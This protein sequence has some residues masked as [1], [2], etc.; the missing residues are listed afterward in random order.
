MLDSVEES[1]NIYDSTSNEYLS[2]VEY[3]DLTKDYLGN[4]EYTTINLARDTE[5]Y[6]LDQMASNEEYAEEQAL[7]VF[8][9][10]SNAVRQLPNKIKELT[11][12]IITKDIGKHID[13]RIDEYFKHH[14]SPQKEQVKS[15]IDADMRDILTELFMQ[16][17]QYSQ[18]QQQSKS[19]FVNLI[20]RYV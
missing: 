7:S 19:R 17:I 3:H 15:G 11:N 10:V 20:Y 9:K 18:N 2:Y 14:V 4:G 12:R 5:I 1:L 8:Q 6:V 16:D 13:K